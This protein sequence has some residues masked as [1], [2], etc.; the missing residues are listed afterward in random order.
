MLSEDGDVFGSFAAST[1]EL[2]T[3]GSFDASA[4]DACPADL[5][6]DG[7]LDLADLQLFVTSFLAGDLAADI[8][9]DGILDLAD[10]QGLVASFNAGCG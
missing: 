8:T 1:G 2:G 6:G 5:T 3:P 10:V 7:I 4:C 9:G